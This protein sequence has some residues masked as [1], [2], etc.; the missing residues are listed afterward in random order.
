MLVLASGPRPGA[1]IATQRVLTATTRAARL[2]S[3]PTLQLGEKD[4]GAIAE[5]AAVR[6]TEKLLMPKRLSPS[7][8][9][10]FRDCAQS[11][12]FRNLWKLPEPPSKVRSFPQRLALADSDMACSL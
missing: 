6:R 3:R 11:F 2:S 10:A 5:C 8:V 9:S 4:L 7:A 1:H 12:L